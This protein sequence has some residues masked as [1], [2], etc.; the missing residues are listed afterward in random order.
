MPWLILLGFYA[1]KAAYAISF[2]IPFSTLGPFATYLSFVD[3][4]WM[5]LGVVSVAAIIGG[6]LGDFIMH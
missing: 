1:K 5:L 2:V 6:Y 4:D 3:M